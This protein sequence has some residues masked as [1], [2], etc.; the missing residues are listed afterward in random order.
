M[1]WR[2]PLA[3]RLSEVWGQQVIVEN[4]GGAGGNVGAYQA[5]NAPPDGYTLLLG[6][7]PY[8]S[9]QSGALSD[10]RLQ[11]V[12]RPRADRSAHGHSQHH[13]GVQFVA[14]PFGS[15]VHRLRQSQPGQRH[16]RVDRHRCV[17]ASERR[18]VQ[19]HGRHRNDARAVSGHRPGHERSGARARQRDVQQ[20]AGRHAA[21]PR[22]DRSRPW[23]YFGQAHCGCAG[24]PNHRRNRAGLRGR[25]PGGACSLP[26]GHRLLSSKNCMPT[27]SLRWATNWSSRAT[28]RSAPRRARRRRPSLRHCC[29]RMPRNGGRS[30]RT[31]A[32]SRSSDGSVEPI[33][34]LDR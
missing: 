16:V 9:D 4:R 5:A 10:L 33:G 28:K 26:P 19:A 2:V 32:S 1:R 29:V 12:H 15:R 20:S 22:Q 27:R 34:F 31:P 24:H 23:H 6:A 17:A 14:G 21:D 25:V 3:Q 13:D 11:S 7:G 8:L 30:S 18:T